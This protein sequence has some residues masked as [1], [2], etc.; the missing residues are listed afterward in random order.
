MTEV[1]GTSEDVWF[2]AAPP[3]HVFSRAGSSRQ[4]VLGAAGAGHWARLRDRAMGDPV[5]MLQERSAI[6]HSAP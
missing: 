2:G 5:T 3:F 6:C 4:Q 1:D